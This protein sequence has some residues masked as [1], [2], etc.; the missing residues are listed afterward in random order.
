MSDPFIGEIR[1]FGFS[2]NPRGWLLCSGGLMPIA[3]ETTL[4]SLLGTFYGGD[5]RTTFA[6]PD[7]RGRT[8]ISYG[9]H[10]GSAKDWQ[11]GERGGSEFHTLSPLELPAHSHNAT[12]TPTSAGVATQIKVSTSEATLNEPADGCYLAVNKAGR[13]PGIK[14]YRPDAGKETVV[15]GGVTGGSSGNGIVTVEPT[16]SNSSFSILQPVLAMNYCIAHVG[17]YP[18]RS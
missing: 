16:G 6:L 9:R 2:F 14:I 11:L 17:T 15:L 5:G 7:L 3:Q 1:L 12:F 4:F 13:N 10:P 8:P 18:P